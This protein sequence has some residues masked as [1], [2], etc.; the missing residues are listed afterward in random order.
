MKAIILLTL[1]LISSL[2]SAK[3]PNVSETKLSNEQ[4]A[5]KALLSSAYTFKV[6]G[7][8]SQ[9]LSAFTSEM[10]EKFSSVSEGLTEMEISSLI[11]EQDLDDKICSESTYPDVEDFN[12][13]ISLKIIETYYGCGC[14]H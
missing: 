9:N 4:V 13:V 8:S 3:C 12:S 11:I 14:E 1:I 10:K 7:I 6:Q 5:V 2:A